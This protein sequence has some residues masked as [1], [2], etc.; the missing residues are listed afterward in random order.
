M[1][2]GITGA[3]RPT[4][5]GPMHVPR[6]TSYMQDGGEAFTPLEIPDDRIPEQ[7]YELMDVPKGLAA[8]GKALFNSPTVRNAFGVFSKEDQDWAE[9]L[10]DLFPEEER[11]GGRGDAARHL[12]AGWLASKARNPRVSQGILQALEHF[13]GQ[14]PN[15][16]S[17]QDN[18]NN[19]IGFQIEAETKEEAEREIQR[20][21][22]QG[23]YAR[24]NDYQ[25]GGA[26]QPQQGGG[27]FLQPD[28]ALPAFNAADY[29]SPA[30]PAPAPAQPAPT[31]FSPYG[32]VYTPDVVAPTYAPTPTTAPAPP[33]TPTD[34][35][36][37]QSYAAAPVTEPLE[38]VSPGGITTGNYLG[39]TAAELAPDTYFAP[40]IPGAGQGFTSQFSDPD[41]MQHLDYSDYPK[42]SDFGSSDEGGHI[43]FKQA[44]N[45]WWQNK[46]NPTVATPPPTVAAPTVAAP[47]VAAPTVAAPTVAAPTVA[48]P[49]VAPP[50][51]PPPMPKRSDYG[52]EEGMD[53]RNDLNDYRSVMQPPQVAP[54]P[55]MPPQVAPPTVAPPTVAPP[56]PQFQP[57]PAPPLPELGPR[58]KRSD[59]GSE[60]RYDYQYDLREWNEAKKARGYQDGG[61]VQHFQDGTE[62]RSQ[63]SLTAEQRETLKQ[64]FV[65]PSTAPAEEPGFI[66]EEGFFNLQNRPGFDMRDLT[67]IVYNPSSK[68]D[69]AL[70]P[71]LFFPPAAAAAKL[72]QLGYKGYKAVRA[73]E[74]LGDL[75]RKIPVAALGNPR[76]TRGITTPLGGPTSG[77]RTYMQANLATELPE[78]I[79]G[80][81]LLD[82]NQD[83]KEPEDF[84]TQPSGGR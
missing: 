83:P 73:M 34:T 7:P 76:N 39:G 15:P 69:N 56:Q 32:S 24:V 55:P 80:R 64:F 21:I 9:S 14:G 57:M 50:V 20:I 60:D 23:N 43:E 27:M 52:E 77:R 71:L 5:L 6:G 13:P 3:S 11:Y 30:A 67:D 37:D 66:A 8:L 18:R 38:F 61:G 75:Q 74:R 31:N 48:A 44:E 1:P 42:R 58:P 78:M 26:V 54:P 41:A 82:R 28:T 59:Y 16:Y 47:T 62:V 81:Y 4:G 29:L 53:Y 65:E 25:D 35:T 33:P 12:A 84:L 68:L 2:K 36:M 51:M 72:A 40:N 45:E 63:G 70:L 17:Q 10:Q 49:T 22:A 19:S 79:H 46:A